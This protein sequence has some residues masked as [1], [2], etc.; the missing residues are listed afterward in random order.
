L[1]GSWS[2]PPG[3]EGGERVAFGL[4]DGGVA[5]VVLGDQRDRLG[6]WGS[7]WGAVACP[8]GG[9]VAGCEVAEMDAGRTHATRHGVRSECG[10]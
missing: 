2:S 9:E 6:L 8:F 10:E 7:V 3:A 4:L 5:L 1:R